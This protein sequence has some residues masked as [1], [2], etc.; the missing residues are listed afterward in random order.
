MRKSKSIKN[1]NIKRNL[2]K[3]NN[4]ERNFKNKKSN[5]KRNLGKQKG[6]VYLFSELSFDLPNYEHIPVGTR[7]TFE[8]P[9]D[10]ETDLVTIYKYDSRYFSTKSANIPDTPEIIHIVLGAV[11]NKQKQQTLTQEKYEKKK[12][13]DG[14]VILHDSFEGRIPFTPTGEKVTSPKTDNSNK[15]TVTDDKIIFTRI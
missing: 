2:T 4:K 12:S 9:E 14:T 13:S 8:F 1:K 6:G 10:N 5:K 3:K 15:F 7:I 11:S